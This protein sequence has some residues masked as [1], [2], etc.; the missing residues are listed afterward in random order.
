M[1]NIGISVGEWSDN[2][3]ANF[4]SSSRRQTWGIEGF[5]PSIGT[6]VRDRKTFGDY[7]E[8]I[9]RQDTAKMLMDDGFSKLDISRL[10]RKYQDYE[11]TEFDKSKFIAYAKRERLI[12]Q[13]RKSEDDAIYE[14]AKEEEEKEIIN[15]SNLFPTN[16]EPTENITSTTSVP[17]KK[18]NKNLYIYS[19]IGL[20]V[21]VGA[22][23]IFKKK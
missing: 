4:G 12:E 13:V 16:E 18:S 15:D 22:F 19:G 6:S 5:T 17:T 7:K 10:W 9:S 8:I 1:K 3:Y 23:L 21:I 11:S 2:Q 14:Q 20:V